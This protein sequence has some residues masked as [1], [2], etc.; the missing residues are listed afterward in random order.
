VNIASDQFYESG[1]FWAGAGTIVGVLSIVAVVWVTW[2]AAN[3]KRRLWYS[4]PVVTPLVRRGKGLTRELKITYGDDQLASPYTV[5]VQFVSRGR[6]DIP[7]SAFDG[8]LPMQLDVGAPIIEVL[9]ITTSRDRPIPPIKV[10]SSKLFIGPSLIGRREKIVISLLVDG[11][12][13]LNPL[14]QSL[15]NVDIRQGDPAEAWPGVMRSPIGIWSVVWLVV[16]VAVIVTSTV[17]T[18]K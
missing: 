7:R 17:F 16:S 18:F 6:L 5:N 8:D 9:N 10:D 1:T 12:P 11:D 4:M 3:P 15:E 13:Q 2:R 14:A